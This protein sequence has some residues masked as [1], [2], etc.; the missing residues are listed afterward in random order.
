MVSKTCKTCG[1]TKPL[2]GFAVSNSNQPVENPGRYKAICKP[3]FNTKRS[4]K[5]ASGEWKTPT[6]TQ[7]RNSR[8]KR[9]YGIDNEDYDAMYH[10]QNGRCGICGVHQNELTKSLAVDHDHETGTVRALLCGKCNRGLGMYDD[11]PFLMEI[12]AEYLRSHGK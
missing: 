7:Q 11:D 1:E 9:Q 8:L 5:V 4:E 3:C 6:L 2:D 12:A 10:Y